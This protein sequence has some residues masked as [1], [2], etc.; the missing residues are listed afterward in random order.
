MAKGLL[1]KHPVICI[2]LL[3]FHTYM[4]IAMVAKDLTLAQKNHV[5]CKE[6]PHSILIK[7]AEAM[8]C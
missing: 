5:F 8:D 4:N 6:H 3:V 1:C 7:L 2:Y